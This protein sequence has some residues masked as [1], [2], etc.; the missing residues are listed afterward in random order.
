P[1]TSGLVAIPDPDL[2]N[3]AGGAIEPQHLAYVIQW[4]L[5]AALALAAPIV[6]APAD[7]PR[8]FGHKQRGDELSDPPVDTFDEPP[9]GANSAARLAD[10]YGRAGRRFG[11]ETGSN[12]DRD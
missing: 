4:F 12:L 2:S 10:A 1:G 11:A 5:F 8:T 3:P 6:M 9:D 7:N